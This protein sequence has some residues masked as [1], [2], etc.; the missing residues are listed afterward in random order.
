MYY[1]PFL[2]ACAAWVLVYP[3]GFIRFKYKPFNC[4]VCLAGWFTLLLSIGH[5][6]WFEVPFFMCVGMVFSVLLTKL[7]AK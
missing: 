7:L 2:A 1:E 4:E 5:Y 3:L 6:R